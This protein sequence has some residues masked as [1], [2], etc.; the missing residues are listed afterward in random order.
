MRASF[1]TLAAGLVALMGTGAMAQFPYT[2]VVNGS[3]TGCYPGQVVTVQ[4][5]NGTLPQQTIS[6]A[7]DSSTCTFSATLGINSQSGTIQLSTM[8]GGAI[9]TA[10][11]SASFNFFLDTAFTNV[12]WICSGNNLDC[13]GIPFGSNV[14]GTACS[15][16]NPN[17]Y[18]DVWQAGCIC[19]GTQ[20]TWCQA[21]FTIQQTSAWNISTT[22]SSIGVLP[23]QYQWLLPDGSSTNLTAPGYTFTTPGVYNMCL[24]LNDSAGCSSTTCDT[25]YVDSLGFISNF[26]PWYDCLG[27]LNGTNTPGSPCDDG[28]SLTVYDTWGWNC[29]CSGSVGQYDCF[30]VWNGPNMPGTACTDTLFGTIITGLWDANCVCSDTNNFFQDCLGIPFGPNM[31][32]TACND[33]DSLTV[34]DIWNS[35]C[36]CAGVIMNPYDCNGVLN[37]PDMPGTS[38]DDND[39]LTLNDMWDI[40]CNCAGSNNAPCQAGFWVLQ[41]Y[42]VDSI[43]GPQ[44]IPNELWIWN[45]STGG[46][47]TYSFLWSFG[48]GTS[49][50]DP[51]PTHLYANGGPYILCL[52]IDDGAGC[53]S[54]SCDSIS[55]D[56]NG[57]YTGFTGGGGDRQSGF[58]INVQNQVGQ[59]VADHTIADGIAIWPNP[60]LDEL[61]IALSNASRGKVDVTVTD[62]NGRLMLTDRKTLTD[63]RNQLL[64]GTEG[65][66]PGLYLLRIANGTQTM[67]Q[68]FVKAN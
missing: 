17:T 58:T 15:D 51:F 52:T 56:A 44:P 4:T 21:S 2:W 3:I 45:L 57:M 42:T 14:V 13:L 6:V 37:G 26:L 5:I 60:A 20:L 9:I 23:I 68:R 8:C 65:L 32:G 47:G 35:A 48:D 61:N 55:V 40:N 7:V 12:N 43:N 66:A 39:P 62:A 54:T 34:Q 64:I 10:Y 36:I 41:G 53:T 50:T 18:N 46:S 19:S 49:S 16:N 24:T 25:V 33:G 27:V 28:D 31:P 67:S 29:V 63:G 59:G 11:D 38:C 30:G 22:N 1:R